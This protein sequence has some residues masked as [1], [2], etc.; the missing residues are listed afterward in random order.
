MSEHE[1]TPGPWQV[2]PT[3]TGTYGK[4][5]V[6]I[7]HHNYRVVHA[8]SF[9]RT[10]HGETET[11]CGVVIKPEDARMIA[12]APELLAAL[13]KALPVLERE[14]GDVFLDSIR[15]AIAKATGKEPA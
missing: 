4:H 10:S 15:S 14:C 5:W 9:D 8:G 6:E 11:H 7:R 1:H 12:A 13:E 2:A 3:P